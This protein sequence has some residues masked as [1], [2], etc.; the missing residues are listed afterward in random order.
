M[1]IKPRYKK[2][3]IAAV[4]CAVTLCVLFWAK[5]FFLSHNTVNYTDSSA[6]I[7]KVNLVNIQI[8]QYFQTESS[9]KSINVSMSDISSAG[10]TRLKLSV[11]NAG[12]DLLLGESVAEADNTDA[13][14]VIL[15]PFD[16]IRINESQKLYFVLEDLSTDSTAAVITTSGHYEESFAANGIADDTRCKFSVDGPD[17]FQTGFFLL[18]A[19]ILC[20][21]AA[22]IILPVEKVMNLP[23]MF[24][25]IALA[26]GISLAVINPPS[27]EA[28]GWEH[29]LRSVDVSYG[30][31]SPYLLRTHTDG[32][33]TVPTNMNS[34]DFHV[35][36]P[37]TDAG[38]EYNANLQKMKFDDTVTNMKYQPNFVS[39]LYIPQALGLMIGRLLGFSMLASVVT[40]RIMNLLAYC[41][42]S[43]YAIKQI[44]IYRNLLTVIALLPMSIYQAASCSPDSLIN[45]FS[46]LFAALCFKYAYDD[47][48]KVK[49]RQALSLGLI[50]SV[51]FI[52]KYVYIFLALLVFII[53]KSKFESA[54]KYWKAF[55]IALIPIAITAVFVY[56]SLKTT[57]GSSQ[58]SSG[59]TTQLQFIMN[60]KF[61]TISVIIE[62]M[63]HYFSIYVDWLNTLGWMNYPLGPLTAIVPCIL[64]GVACL[65]KNKYDLAIKSWQKLLFAFVTIITIAAMLLGLY[66]GD[67]RINPVGAD[68]ILGIQGRYFIPIFLV[69]FAALTSSKIENHIDRFSNKIVSMMAICLFY[70]TVCLVRFCF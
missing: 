58:A 28:D 57:I 35:I 51:I 44:P 36:A 4:V 23:K 62:T 42:I 12:T 32:E 20:I 3:L 63:N 67:G 30:N 29:F 14:T 31:L 55:G 46:F 6:E 45:A 15:F 26:G 49:I 8:K 13:E 17:E 43:Y 70:T 41:L 53:P 40:A 34:F 52:S 59:G 50:I 25:L 37:N 39:F 47:N 68:M 33:L 66:I 18:S 2:L 11:Y 21:A 69:A 9:I 60:N 10:K 56:L 48:A 19:L 65:D 38:D 7:Q 1:E 61:H 64:V 22:L 5:G 27:Q 54:K 16:T 24:L